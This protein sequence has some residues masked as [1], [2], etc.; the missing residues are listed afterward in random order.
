MKLIVG[1]GNP[2]KEY[3]YSR[4]NVGFIILNNYFSDAN[5]Q[6]KDNY[7]YIEKIF[8]NEKVIFIKPLTYMNLSG[9]AVQK[10][11]NF[12]KIP[13]ENILIIH[14]DLDLPEKTVRFKFNSSAG[15]H[16]G[17]KS[18][19]N[20]L[21]TTRFSHLKVGIGRKEYSDQKDYV[22]SNLSKDEI[23]FL[24]NDK[25]IQMINTFI[26]QGITICMN[27]YNSNGD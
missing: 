10:I 20:S 19:I 21:G 22:L 16:N 12:Y 15:G 13:V 14:D 27:R 23:N 17:I 25:F 2:G 8:N 7:E 11:V 18:I 26:E 5:W 6:K 4:H 9:L 3:E 1:L 24:Q